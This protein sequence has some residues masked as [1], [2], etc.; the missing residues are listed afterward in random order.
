MIEEKT[1]P[2]MDP[3]DTTI[4]LRGARAGDEAAQARLFEHLYSE[5]R[6]L[7]RSNLRRRRADLYTTELVHEAFLKLCKGQAVVAGD[8]SH[9]FALAARAMRQVL[10]DHFRRG[11]AGKRG[12]TECPKT[13]DEEAVSSLRDGELVL[14]IDQALK[15]FADFDQRAAQVVELKFFGGLTEP[16]IGEV[17][18]ISIRS[19]SGDWRCARAW[20]NRQLAA[21]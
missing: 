7:A 1:R 18:G 4:L 20:L 13:L 19:V 8:R 10:V 3:H 15:R 6:G 16:E 17:L 2:A 12:G 9:F 21:S 5:L 11:V 14:L